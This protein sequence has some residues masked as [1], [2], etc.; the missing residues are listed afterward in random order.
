M[1]YR[2]KKTIEYDEWIATQSAKS[3]VQ[4]A[5]RLSNIE[6]HGHFGTIKDVHDGVWE[7]KWQNGRRVYYVY[8]PEANILLLIGGSKNG[9]SYD[10]SQA[11]KILRKYAEN[12]T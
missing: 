9:Q 4:I 10:I 6:Q 12:E 3:K 11:K 5:K 7:L 8:I 2:I 1:Q